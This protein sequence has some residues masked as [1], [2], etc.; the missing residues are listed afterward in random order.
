MKTEPVFPK[1]NQEIENKEVNEDEVVNFNYLIIEKLFDQID[2]VDIAP[3]KSSAIINGVEYDKEEVLAI[4]GFGVIFLFIENNPIDPDN[5]RKLIIKFINTGSRDPDSELLHEAGVPYI[6]E[7]RGIEGIVKVKGIA[8]T[9]DIDGSEYAIV[10]SHQGDDI[11]RLSTNYQKKAKKAVQSKYP[12]LDYIDYHNPSIWDSLSE[13]EK[14]DITRIETGIL[15]EAFDLL[16]D[17]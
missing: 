1:G 11:I 4:G 7:Q 16:F 3:D 2:N 6:C 10:F 9:K 8:E 5:P 13:E 17:K 12:K 14:V 15:N